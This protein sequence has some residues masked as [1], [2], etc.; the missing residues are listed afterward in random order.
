MN[1]LKNI[2]KRQETLFE[3]E[4]QV[5]NSSSCKIIRRDPENDLDIM[6]A[7]TLFYVKVLK[8]MEV[9]ER[10]A[11]TGF[12]LGLNRLSLEKSAGYGEST[13]RTVN[14][15]KI[16]SRITLKL[17]K[18]PDNEKELQVSKL[19]KVILSEYIFRFFIFTLGSISTVYR[20]T[21]ISTF[22]AISKMEI[23][24]EIEVTANK[25]LL[26]FYVDAA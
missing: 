5:S 8:Q 6:L 10:N 18:Y 9:A 14:A 20:R 17:V 23:A 7:C 16:I 22:F 26:S 25:T 4:L 15:Q 3:L 12:F 24:G 1:L 2:L 21:L 13:L 19:H 11:I